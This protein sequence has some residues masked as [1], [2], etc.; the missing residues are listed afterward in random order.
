M[1]EKPKRAADYPS[2]QV[3]L[4][5]AVC[6]YVATELG[7]LMDDL[8]VVG[9]LVPSLLIDPGALPEGTAAHVGI[10]DLDVG[11]KLALLDEGRYQTLTE[12]L[13]DSG[14][15][16]DENDEGRPT[17]PGGW[18]PPGRRRSPARARSA[19]PRRRPR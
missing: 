9:G 3:A 14:F 7:D 8:V 10:L 19:V 17:R 4:V 2:E 15:E 5:R 1:P 16:P 11:L 12:R 13:R 18:P 6:L